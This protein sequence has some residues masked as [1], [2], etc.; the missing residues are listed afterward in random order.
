MR[1]AVLI[2]TI[3]TTLNISCATGQKNSAPNDT[4]MNNQLKN[5]TNIF[6]KIKPLMLI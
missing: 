2:A 4:D 3:F 6:L 5:G 1:T